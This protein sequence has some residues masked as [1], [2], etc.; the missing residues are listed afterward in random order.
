ME[1]YNHGGASTV[2]F[3]DI[4]EKDSKSVGGHPSLSSPSS[5]YAPRPTFIPRSPFMDNEKDMTRTPTTP[6]S[7]AAPV[8]PSPVNNQDAKMSQSGV[9][10]PRGAHL[11]SYRHSTSSSSSTVSSSSLSHNAGGSGQTIAQQWPPRSNYGYSAGMGMD[12]LRSYTGSS[13]QHGNVGG[14]PPPHPDY[15]HHHLRSGQQSCDPRL[16]VHPQSLAAALHS[17]PAKAY[18]S[19]PSESHGYSTHHASRYSRPLSTGSL[20][21]MSSSSSRPGF[22]SLDEFPNMYDHHSTFAAPRDDVMAQRLRYGTGPAP[23]ATT[24]SSHRQYQD[25]RLSGA[26]GSSSVYAGSPL[27]PLSSCDDHQPLLSLPQQGSLLGDASSDELAGQLTNEMSRRLSLQDQRTLAQS[28]A[29]GQPL[30]TGRCQSNT[31]SCIHIMEHPKD[32][33][34][35]PNEKAVLRCTARIISGNSQNREK[36]VELGEEPNL[37]W[38]KDAE[39]LIGEIDCEY[40]VE[41]VS[42][43]DIGFYYC[44]VSHPEDEGVKK[45]SDMARLTIKRRAEGT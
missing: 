8:A 45:P 12:R 33:E 19:Y 16:R 32:L 38:Y 37:L 42:E 24:H 13:F 9:M 29:R 43:K 34:V 36:E 23:R 21:S 14:V 2:H 7:P 1:P 4:V 17:Q 35:F 3:S 27:S 6:K 20:S 25:V 11:P 22:S 15:H 30:P 10:M 31:E 18:S 41:E 28:E 26:V 44:L 40:V 5:Q 39:P